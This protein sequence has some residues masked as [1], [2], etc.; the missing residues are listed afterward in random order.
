MRVLQR[1]T[2]ATVPGCRQRQVQA[3]NC[4]LQDS[5][6]AVQ[7]KGSAPAHNR[8]GE[9]WLWAKPV[10]FRQVRL[11]CGDTK[12]DVAFSNSFSETEHTSQTSF[13]ARN[14]L[15]LNRTARQTAPSCCLLC[16][17]PIIRLENIATTTRATSN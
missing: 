8:A 4:E 16:W 7:R 13:S 1:A 10:N 15:A 9:G 11:S 12:G 14:P 5:W 6:K 17:A 2:A 3:S